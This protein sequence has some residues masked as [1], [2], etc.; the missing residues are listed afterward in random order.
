MQKDKFN[1]LINGKNGLCLINQND[2]YI[3]KSME[4][5]GEYSSFETN[6]FEDFCLSGDTVIEVGS[7]I[8]VHTQELASMVTQAGKVFAFEPQRVVF[9]TLC[10]N[11]SLN[12]ISNVYA[13]NFAVG[14]ENKQINIPKLDY[15][16]QNNYGGISLKEVKDGEEVQ[17]VTLDFFENKLSSLKF[18]KVDVEGMEYD[19]LKG[20][21][22]LIKK[23]KPILYLENDRIEHSQRVLDYL[24]SLGYEIYWHLPPLYNPDNFFKN[25]NN[26]FKN[27]ISINILCLPKDK[28]FSFDL[29]KH[30]LQ[31]VINTNLHPMKAEYFCKLA[32]DYIKV[33][34]WQEAVNSYQE[35]L[36]SNPLHLKTYFNFA[37][38]LKNL[39][40]YDEAL[41]LFLI[42]LKYYPNDYNIHNNIGMVFESLGE[43]NKAIEAYKNAIK[44]NP[45]FA[46][47]V[48]NL[49][50]VLYNQ[51]R[52]KESS[53]MFSLALE[54]E[55]DYNEV[56]SNL[57][58]ALNRQKRYD[59]S[60]KALNM[61]IEKL[62][63]NAG[64]YTNLGNV[65][66]KLH[67]YEKAQ[68]LHEKSIELEPN[69]ANAYSNLASSL[70]N[71]GLNEEAIKN[72]KKAIQ[73]SPDFV[74]AHFDLA[75]TLLTLNRF[76]EGFEE[77][78]WRF[79]KEE[80]LGHIV[81]YKD[82]FSKPMLKKDDNIEGKTLLLHSEQGFGDSIQFIRFLPLIKE[83]FKCKIAVK[84]RDE[85]KELFKT[86]E[87]IDILV[88]RSEDTPIFD[89]H[90]PI[91]SMPFILNMKSL[92][93]LPKQMPYLKALDDEFLKIKKD[94]K[95]I[96]IGICWSASI[97]GESYDGKV[98]D[99]KYLEPLINHP[100]INL[101]SLQVG[102][103][104]EHIKKYGYEDE[105]IDLTDKLTDF[106]KTASLIKQLDLVIS[107]DT[108]VAHLCGAINAPVWI[109]LQK[110]PDWR[111]TN[112]GEST[113]W[114]PSAKLFRQ[115]S[116]R[117]W[118]SVFQS[119]YAKL[120]KQ[121]KIKDIRF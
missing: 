59:E 79:K 104:N 90:L 5:Y 14:S 21:S 25:K 68:K 121:F 6:L 4:N 16:K 9:Q 37:S 1:K 53:D 120:S 110:Y 63:N 74:N 70:K 65:Y 19:V 75:T 100:K 56:Y 72:Y 64:A 61:A 18:I 20:S 23:Y 117:A 33:Q 103:E 27:L 67:E 52:Y 49:A 40:K 109:P 119:L 112:K 43:N 8:G 13:Y 93:D 98:F 78:E 39:K 41:K 51:Q 29:E 38:L 94:K 32:F 46:K 113:K 12:S 73:L 96:D 83:K 81:K 15:S 24:L 102:K 99:L 3:G 17:Q 92:D 82:I 34:K 80:M 31:K 105:I 86:I 44:I 35:A 26:I 22:N 2:I 77:Y 87:E 85:L 107:S 118:D 111:W 45:K 11:L 71:Q 76:D 114:Y 108:S 55:P 69:G 47:A 42:A 57:G 58:A 7:N 30:S 101:Y 116:N 36:K 54:I 97:T 48:N 88:N 91:M 28:D 66:N 60:I 106:S 62:P 50:V 10:A 95:K 115:K 89:Y 84:C